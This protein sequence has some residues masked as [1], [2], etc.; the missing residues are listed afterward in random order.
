M[1]DHL[2]AE[3]RPSKPRR[4]TGKLRVAIDAIVHQGLEMDE[5]A[6]LAGMTTRNVRM[7]LDRPWVRAHLRQERA[8]LVDELTAANPHHLRTMRAGSPNQMVRLAAVRTLEDIGNG[9]GG[10]RGTSVNVNVN[11]Q[12]G[13]VLDLRED[14]SLIDITP[15]R[16]AEGDE[17][18]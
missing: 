2:P 17:K 9:G 13:Y 4:V 10:G 3:Q 6:A 18:Q 15:I 7:A 8:R 5:A 16:T 14:R 1:T 12:A 11:V